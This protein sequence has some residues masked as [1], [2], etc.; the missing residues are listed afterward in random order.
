MSEMIESAVRQHFAEDI[1]ESGAADGA[2]E[3]KIKPESVLP[4][5]QFLK[6]TPAL[7]FDYPA[8]I[9]GV[10]RQDRIELIYHLTSMAKG[11]KIVLRTDLN[12]DDPS[13]D[14]VTPVWRGANWQEREIYDLLGV[15]FKNHPELRRIL[16]PDDW[17][18]YPLRKDYVI[19]EDDR[20]GL[21]ED[22]SAEWETCKPEMPPECRITDG[23]VVCAPGKLRTE[24]IQLNM[25]PQHP[26]THGVLRVELVLDGEVVIDAKPDVGY[27]HR[28]MEKLAEM[29]SYIQ[30]IPITDRF[31]YLASMMNNAAYVG[32]IEKLAGIE[33][34]EKA[35]YIR[36]IVMELQRIASHLVY[37]GTM[38]LDLGATT[39]FLYAFRERELILDLFEMTCGA[40]LTYNYF[41]PGG[42]SRDLTACFDSKCRAYIKQQRAMLREYN[43][44]LTDNEIFIIRMRDVGVISAE[45]ATEYGLSGPNIRGSGVAY[46]VRRSDPYSIYD[47]FE[48]NVATQ[49]AG[50]SLSRFLVR[51]QEISESLKIIEQALDGI[52]EGELKYKLPAVFKAPAGEA[53][54]H[55]ESARGDLGVYLVSDGTPKPYRMK[56]RAPSFITLQALAQMVRG[57]KVADVVA[58]LGSLDVVLGEVDR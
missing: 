42:V 38:G 53:Y 21:P 5:C 56:W 34:S 32:A 47:R 54:H 8:S 45:D 48:F 29:R 57:W 31:D 35:E 27:L 25:G 10:D 49:P 14:S 16:L 13:V 40:R 7:H 24:E 1:I 33:V 36:V 4:I 20:H 11:E 58:I 15:R 19:P 30:F 22:W 2:V 28:G 18:G 3:L 6:E 44:L 9:T 50:D 23:R 46:D 43:D 41:R 17:E 12:R 51:V 37:F 52:P 39:P 26:S 55:I